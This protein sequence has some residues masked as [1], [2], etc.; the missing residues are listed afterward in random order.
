MDDR[1][2]PTAIV[3]RLCPHCDARYRVVAVEAGSEHRLQEIICLA[4]GGPLRGREGR[5]VLKYFLVEARKAARA[6]RRKAG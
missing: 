1:T 6:N 2:E 4:C 3:L 5:Y